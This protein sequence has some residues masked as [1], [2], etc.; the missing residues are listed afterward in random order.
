M[1]QNALA[2]RLAKKAVV[3]S[4]VNQ[5]V[6]QLQCSPA[7]AVLILT[8]RLQEYSSGIY[9]IMQQAGVRT[10]D[11]PEIIKEIASGMGLK[12]PAIQKPDILLAKLNNPKQT[13]RAVVVQLFITYMETVVSLC[14]ET[15]EALNVILQERFAASTLQLL[16]TVQSAGML[17][18]LAVIIN[19]HSSAGYQ[20]PEGSSIVYTLADFAKQVCRSFDSNVD[21]WI[22]GM[23][24]LSKE[25]LSLSC[26]DLETLP[27]QFAEL[28]N[29][30]RI[31]LC[32]RL[33][34]THA[35][36]EWR[37]WLTSFQEVE[38]DPEDMTKG[39]TACA[40]RMMDHPVLTT[41]TALCW[42]LTHKWSTESQHRQ[43]N[44]EAIEH[45][46]RIMI[47][48]FNQIFEGNALTPED[49]TP[50]IRRHLF[51]IF[52][53][54]QGSSFS[55]N[56]WKKLI[57]TAYLVAIE[58]IDL[59]AFEPG[60]VAYDQI[61]FHTERLEWFTVRI[62]TN[63]PTS[64]FE[65]VVQSAEGQTE[66]DLNQEEPTRRLFIRVR[67]WLPTSRSLVL[68]SP[69]TFNSSTQARM[70]THIQAVK[71][72]CESLSMISPLPRAKGVYSL[73]EPNQH[74]ISVWTRFTKITMPPTEEHK[75]VL[76][77]GNSS[78]F[79]ASCLSAAH[80]TMTTI[81]CA[82]DVMMQG[83][84]YRPNLGFSSSFVPP[85]L[86]SST[87]D[88][89]SP[90]KII[91]YHGVDGDP[92]STTAMT[93]IVTSAPISTGSVKASFLDLT[94]IEAGAHRLVI[95][96]ILKV[97]ARNR[98][99]DSVLTVLISCSNVHI[100]TLHRLLMTS[101]H[102]TM[103]VFGTWNMHPS[104][105]MLV[106]V[107]TEAKNFNVPQPAIPLSVINMLE[108]RL[109]AAHSYSPQQYHT[110]QRVITRAQYNNYQYRVTSVIPMW[111]AL[112]PTMPWCLCNLAHQAAQ[113]IS[114][115]GLSVMSKSL[116]RI[117]DKHTPQD[118]VAAN[119][120]ILI[121]GIRMTALGKL[122]AVCDHVNI[123][124]ILIAIVRD[125][126]E[127][128]FGSSAGLLGAVVLTPGQSRMFLDVPTKHLSVVITG[129]AVQLKHQGQTVNVLDAI[130]NAMCEAYD[131]CHTLM[132]FRSRPLHESPPLAEVVGEA[133]P[134]ASYRVCCDVTSL[135][136]YI[137]RC[138]NIREAGVKWMPTRLTGIMLRRP[139]T[140]IS[141]PP[142][143]SN[144]SPVYN[145]ESPEYRV[146]HP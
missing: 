42:C 15:W 112:V 9:R 135:D 78:G 129:M 133:F 125:I 87:T 92:T 23:K 97:L 39:I 89:T 137:D 124:D 84:E 81:H 7:Q 88:P 143:P 40:M 18:D 64:T 75:F 108:M 103:D 68:P 74:A 83:V 111:Q 79:L 37:D 53:S 2:V 22:T 1:I 4:T 45:Q 121:T 34:R 71:E 30:A 77:V 19:D 93:R 140:P 69:P 36:Y 99:L 146:Y 123:Y 46:A 10:Y 44:E 56:T 110:I 141:N 116:E 33:Y 86:A 27:A 61:K 101:V 91:I 63:T 127:M 114:A 138:N 57:R 26:E 107:P 113:A 24:S 32:Y 96:N 95:H 3:P 21:V 58:S 144:Q 122:L 131:I 72:L 109:K 80:P 142:T 94:M 13:A 43:V 28:E 128:I 132:L 35:L 52:D 17:P 51:S 136:T 98:C 90:R 117:R 85:E 38:E 65:K 25:V 11:D 49:Y 100:P 82:T 12:L 66:D 105:L 76:A 139:G 73:V 48:V 14:F 70:M 106:V 102:H 54:L 29:I 31:F 55:R 5:L 41:F 115:Y 8:Q 16:Y 50:G 47:L 59:V 120:P 104:C 119:I 6:T 130:E 118:D 20:V 145:P 62:I 60:Q 126:L 67:S 134:G